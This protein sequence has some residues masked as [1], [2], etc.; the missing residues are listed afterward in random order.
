MGHCIQALRPD[1]GK[2]E[3]LALTVYN[4]YVRR[5]ERRGMYRAAQQ[6]SHRNVRV[7]S[8]GLR[9]LVFYKSA[10][11]HQHSEFQQLFE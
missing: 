6:R 11:H 4:A 1:S 5:R 2:T 8:S 3:A 7:H 9:L 10:N